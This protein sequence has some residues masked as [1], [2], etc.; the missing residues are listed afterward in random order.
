MNI[1]S[2]LLGSLFA[3]LALTVQA[4]DAP[5]VDDNAVWQK[6]WQQMQEY[7]QAW[8]S[9]KTPQERQKLQAEHWQSMQPGFGMMGGCPMAGSG[10]AGMGMKGGKGMMPGGRMTGAPTKEMLDMRIQHME[11]MLEQMRSHR[12]MLDKQ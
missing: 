3:A 10:G 12:E 7:R 4:Q 8:Q 2:C 5:P 9:A 11:Q 6:H 1:R